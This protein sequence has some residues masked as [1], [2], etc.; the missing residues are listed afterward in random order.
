M[1]T[2]K[3]KDGY[4]RRKTPRMLTVRYLTLEEI[5]NLSPGDHVH[6]VD[7]WGQARVI[8]INGQVRRWKR[9]PT[10]FEVPWKYGMYEYGTYTNRDGDWMIKEVEKK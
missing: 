5:L 1:K 3:I 9:D 2:F 4:D 8:K 7:K 6:V 10:R